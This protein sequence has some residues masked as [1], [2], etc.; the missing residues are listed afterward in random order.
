MSLLTTLDS[1]EIKEIPLESSTALSDVRNRSSKHRLRVDTANKDFKKTWKSSEE[2][3]FTTTDDTAVD[4][5]ISMKPVQEDPAIE[6]VLDSEIN[7][8]PYTFGKLLWTHESLNS[9]FC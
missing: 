5:P 9:K 3:N 7:L 8:K 6:H 1:E 4:L 2:R